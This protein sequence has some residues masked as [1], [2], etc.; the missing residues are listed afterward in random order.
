LTRSAGRSPGSRIDAGDRPSRFPSGTRGSPAIRLQLRG[1]LR[2]W[3]EDRTGFPFHPQYGGTV[4][5][6]I[7]IAGLFAES[8]RTRR[9][10][11][12]LAALHRRATDWTNGFDGALMRVPVMDVRVVR[13]PVDQTRMSM[14]VHMRLARRVARGVRVLMVLVV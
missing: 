2:H 14:D 5:G 12:P 10:N 6:T 7:A 1:Q 11:E 3:S 9:R 8:R 4:A 13:M